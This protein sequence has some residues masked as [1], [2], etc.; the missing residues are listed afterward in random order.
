MKKHWRV[1]MLFLLNIINY[2]IQDDV[3]KTEEKFFKVTEQGFEKTEG[4]QE[5]KA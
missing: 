4:I 1:P 2:V 3:K 5:I